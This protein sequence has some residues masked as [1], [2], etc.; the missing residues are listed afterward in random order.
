MYSLMRWLRCGAWLVAFAMLIQPSSAARQ[1]PAGLPRAAAARGAQAITVFAASDLNLAFRQIIPLFERTTHAKATLVPGSSGTLAQQIANGAPADLFF[2]AS[3]RDID[4]LA[5]AGLILPDTRTLYARG[6]IVL[7]AL[8]SS[9]V[10]VNGLRDLTSPGIRRVAIANPT[11]AP[12]GLAAQQALE[13][14]GLWSLV[15]PKLVFGENVQQAVQLV[16]SGAADA[17]IVARSLTESPGIVWTPIDAALHA[18]LDQVAAVLARTRQRV[19][20]ISF[21]TLVTGYQ[22]RPIMERFG[23][24]LPGAF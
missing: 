18:P 5:R 3:E 24:L 9:A 21:L 23:F 14:S 20:A 4:D 15:Q 12:Y 7:I 2:A 11:H 10:Q 6:Q 16:Q 19:L 22:G 17:G 1:G 13:S 8:K